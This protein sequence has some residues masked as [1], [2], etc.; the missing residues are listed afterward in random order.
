MFCIIFRSAAGQGHIHILQW[1]IE[2]GADLKIKNQNGES[3]ID[4]AKRFAQLACIKLLQAEICKFFCVLGA[5]TLV[6][7]LTVLI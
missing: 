2:N 6:L 4:V 7:N 1:L 5:Y 3:P